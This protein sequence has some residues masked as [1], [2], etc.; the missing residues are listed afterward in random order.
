M[1]VARY[2]ARVSLGL[3]VVGYAW[4]A[5]GR[6]R[7][8]LGAFVVAHLVHF[9]TMVALV[10]HFPRA[11][12]P[13]ELALGVVAYAWPTAMLLVPGQAETRWRRWGLHYVW[14]SF[15]VTYFHRLFEFPER[16]AAGA[17]AF[18]LIVGAALMRI[19]AM[20]RAR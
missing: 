3:F 8:W 13:H 9:A 16:R 17:F 1:L 5:I 7:R 15:A 10:S 4:P 2:T 19:L 14:L 11:P 20:W 6:D 18:A 12:H